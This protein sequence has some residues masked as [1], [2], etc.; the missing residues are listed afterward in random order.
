MG[1]TGGT[2]SARIFRP[3]MKYETAYSHQAI[4]LSDGGKIE[5]LVLTTNQK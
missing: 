5:F 3:V 2:Y 4:Y 1:T